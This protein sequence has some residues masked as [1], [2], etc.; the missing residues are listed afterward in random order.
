M[1]KYKVLLIVMAIILMIVGLVYYRNYYVKDLLLN[2]KPYSYE[3]NQEDSSEVSV[4]MWLGGANKMVKYIFEDDRVIQYQRIILY[5]QKMKKIV[6]Y[7][8][9][10]MIG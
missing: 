2:Q 1:K 9:I 8:R 7:G 10:S 4:T 6:S 3:I 5:Y